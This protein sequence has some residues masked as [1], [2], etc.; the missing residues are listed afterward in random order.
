MCRGVGQRIPWLFHRISS[1]PRCSGVWSYGTYALPMH[2]YKLVCA[3]LPSH[4]GLYKQQHA[5][6]RSCVS[7]VP[8]YSKWQ[9]GSY[10]SLIASHS[11][12][13][14]CHYSFPASGR[15]LEKANQIRISK[16]FTTNHAKIEVFPSSTQQAPAS[17]RTLLHKGRTLKITASRTCGCTM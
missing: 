2:P 5:L 11:M 7:K 15:D 6:I 3:A 1:Y 17:P 13:L 10:E 14:G 4:G 12:K 9:K 8:V 16:S